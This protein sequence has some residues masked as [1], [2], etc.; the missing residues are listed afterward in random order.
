MSTRKP[1]HPRFDSLEPKT[2]MSAGVATAPLAAAGGFPGPVTVPSRDSHPRVELTGPANGYYTSTQKS[3]GT[4]TEYDLTA[5]GTISP[6]GS[7]VI[8]GSFQTVQSKAS[9][10]LTIA[11]S[12]GTLTLKLRERGPTTAVSNGADGSINPGGPIRGLTS[13]NGKTTS[14]SGGPIILVN[15]FTYTIVRGTGAYARARGSGTVDITTT[16]G[17]SSPP[18][19][20]IY[21]SPSTTETGFGTTTLTFGSGVVPVA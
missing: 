9:G 1:F 19:P 17:I 10:I 13:S 15:D 2:V 8:T 18:G 3:N 5:A 16:P 4:E 11:G 7:A 20:G 12:P 14:S 6:V 21:A